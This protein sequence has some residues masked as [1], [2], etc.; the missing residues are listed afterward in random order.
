MA[1]PSRPLSPPPPAPER[2]AAWCRAHGPWLLETL[3]VYALALTVGLVAFWD[4]WDAL[5][6]PL[7]NAYWLFLFVTWA[8]VRLGWWGT[9]GLLL[10]IGLQAGWGTQQGL[11]FFARDLNSGVWLG[12]ASYM[13]ILALVGWSLAGYLAAL[14]RQKADAR[15]A[16][17]AFEC[18]EGLLITDAQGRILRANQAFQTLSGHDCTQV[19]GQMPHF[20]L[21]HG[22]AEPLP[23]AALQRQEWH[24]RRSGERY[25]VWFTRTPVLGGRG[26]VTHYVLTMTDLSDWRAQRAQRRQRELQLRSA[27]VREVHH[28]IKNN[29]Q[30]ISGMLQTLA[31][32]YPALREPLTEATGQVQSIAVLHGLQGRGHAEQVQLCELLRDVA[33]GVG[34]LWGLPLAFDL[35]DCCHTCTLLSS[36]AVPLALIVHELLVNAIK[37]GGQQ[38]QDVSMALA[39]GA[40]PGHMLITISNP[41]QWPAQGPQPAQVGLELVAA[42]MPRHGAALQLRQEGARALAELQLQPPVLQLPTDG[43]RLP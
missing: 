33:Q 40:Q 8:G 26:Q 20:L 15:I 29:L 7:G 38:A 6:W 12:Y 2:L 25:P 22:S 21:A 43:E 18:Q 5:L 14:R 31:L 16:A 32:R 42:L 35:D 36:E 4:W 10:L 17:I 24:R 13:L 3:L 19:V 39:P 23:W 28:R 41:G 27:L 30:G 34:A 1:H 11:G 9:T 37:H